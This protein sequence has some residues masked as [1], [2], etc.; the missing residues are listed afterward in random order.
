MPLNP[1]EIQEL[2][3]F[4]HKRSDSVSLVALHARTGMG[5]TESM[6]R[7]DLVAWVEFLTEA[8]TRA[9]LHTVARLIQQACPDDQNL[10]SIC[11][12][13]DG[14]TFRRFETMTRYAKQTGFGLMGAGALGVLVGLIGLGASLAPETSVANEFSKQEVPVVIE[15]ALRSDLQPQPK[16][17][18][19]PQS[20]STDLQPQPRVGTLPSQT[21]G[22]ALQPQPKSAKSQ[23]ATRLTQTDAPGRRGKLTRRCNVK[24][25]EHIG[26]FHWGPES[27]GKPPS[28]IILAHSVNVRD[29]YPRFTN[30]YSTSAAIRCILRTGEK[31]QLS[32]DAILVAGGHYWIPVTA[33]DLINS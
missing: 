8:N 25:G 12:I 28:E 32:S 4:F 24:D 14:N 5:L 6:T 18:L 16:V 15:Q 27:N 10:Q 1:S 17:P 2:A 26:F 11:S 20:R 31:I 23:R 19:Q 29:D 22:T 21:K 9:Q 30:Q 13:L 33:R 3:C 7:E